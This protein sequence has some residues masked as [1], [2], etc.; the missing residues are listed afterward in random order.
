[1]TGPAIKILLI[2]DNPGDADLVRERLAD[3]KGF[4][5][6]L[7]VV[8]HLADGM[9]RA[10][11]EPFDLV[12]LD[13][14]LPDSRG[15]DTFERMY[16]TCPHVPIVVLTGLAD[17]EASMEAM[18]KGAQDYLIKGQINPLALVRA[19]RYA[20]ERKR[21]SEALRAS[22]DHLRFV[23]D[24]LG[25][26]QWELDLDHDTARRSLRHDQIFGYES[27]V[28]E[29]GYKVFL[30]HVHTLDRPYVERSFQNAVENNREWEC[31]CRIIRADEVI[32]WIWAK[33]MRPK[34]EASA[35]RKML[36][37][38]MD[39]T[40]RKVR[41][42]SAQYL[43]TIVRS[44]DD[45][46]LSQSLDGMI[47]S[48]NPGAAKLY[49]YTEP[50]MIGRPVSVLIPDGHAD[51]VQ[52][53]LNRVRKGEAIRHFE[54]VRRRKN[55]NLLD[56]SLSIS[57]I[58]GRGGIIGAVS[59]AR[60]ITER[61][62]AEENVRALNRELEQRVRERTAQ[63][64]TANKELESFAYSV[65][66][67]LRAP[68]RAVNGFVEILL[69]EHAQELA[70]QPRHYL[71]V[72]ADNARKM[73]QLIDDLL[74]FSRL[75][76]Q[77]MTRDTVDTKR[78]VESCLAE[79]QAGQPPRKLEIALDTLPPC[80]GDPA[81]LKQVWLNLLSNALKF[82][83]DRDPARIEVGCQQQNGRPVYYVRDNG[84]GFDMRY[85]D[86][87]F[88]VF[89]RLHSAEEFEGTGVGLALVQHIV[90][91][92]GGQAWAEAKPNEGA[93]FFFTVNGEHELPNNRNGKEATQ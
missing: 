6:E 18:R 75:G 69:Q 74:R 63:L 19:V 34:S 53:I 37:L 61:K 11:S 68:L 24:A 91:R 81:L 48:W 56:V 21:Q 32:R 28:P 10:S 20:I 46:I 13:L 62:Q 30:G 5:F 66:H 70:D 71:T 84:V 72:V 25:V 93:T 39:I 33:G 27:L 15:M 77:A 42:E 49:G 7:G 29:W 9:L 50:E 67:D 41:E 4:A 38:V 89:Q 45:A 79:L 76:R 83:R 82:T 92:H 58:L 88:G 55:G 36:G 23:L 3:A 40:E 64:E 73:G 51:E 2:E 59:I 52:T 87:L 85:A 1:M 43:A 31:E 86:K 47:V 8:D 60:D 17:E 12:L 78:L 65:S 90:R 16:R 35:P 57:P 26:G 14:G 54:T 44:S 22:E 80:Q